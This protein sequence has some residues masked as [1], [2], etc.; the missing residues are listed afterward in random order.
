MFTSLIFDMDGLM[1]DTEGLYWSAAR[2]I[3]ADYHKTVSD[4]TLRK[5]MGR[6][7]I[8]SMRVFA[9][10]LQL[11]DSPQAL[12]DRRSAMM[13]ELFKK[14]ITPMPGLLDLLRAF[15]G[16]L[17]LAVAT[18]APRAFTDLILPSM[19]L[20]K[21]FDAVQTSDGV[22]HGKPHPEIYL[23]A[24]ARLGAHPQESI[25]LEDSAA[26]ARAGKA[27]GAYTIAVPSQ[28]TRAE[29]FDFADLRAGSLADAGQ[30]IEN[31]LLKA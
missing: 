22:T 11:P 14:P 15:H 31:L 4:D 5:M 28:Y 12:L 18:S 25:V 7:P 1:I 26:G 10:D 19:G 2:A 3:A 16:R 24:I 29:N 9:Q 30:E 17:K 8:D 6:A 20:Q 13:L 21:F 27:A 23:K